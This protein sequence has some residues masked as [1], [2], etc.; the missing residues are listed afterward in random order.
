M[1]KRW[2]EDEDFSDDKRASDEYYTAEC[3]NCDDETEHDVC[4]DK[5]VECS[6]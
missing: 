4:T 6:G 3:W 1:S 5:C 2:Y